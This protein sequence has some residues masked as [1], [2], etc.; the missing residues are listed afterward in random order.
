MRRFSPRRADIVAGTVVVVMLFGMLA[1][2]AQSSRH[3]RP[4]LGAV[5]DVLFFLDRPA[6]ALGFDDRSVGMVLARIAAT[7][8]WGLV[9]GWGVAHCLLATGR[10][11]GGRVRQ[12]AS[13]TGRRH[14]EVVQ[15][16][17]RSARRLH[18]I[19]TLALALLGLCLLGAFLSMFVL[20]NGPLVIL[21]VRAAVVIG[22]IT[23]IGA[24]VQYL[25]SRARRRR[26]VREG[27]AGDG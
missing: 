22:A 17:G 10:G 6:L 4:F 14:E 18:P 5:L 25:L 16:D 7:L 21:C 24:P 19:W 15:E 11:A 26:A 3:P 13:S 20:A 9:L 23:L 8:T 1:P 27:D 12:P 2:G